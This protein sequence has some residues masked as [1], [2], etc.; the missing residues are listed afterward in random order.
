MKQQY[1][2]HGLTQWDLVTLGMTLLILL[3]FRQLKKL[4]GINPM[5]LS[6]PREYSLVIIYL[7]TV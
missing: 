7:Q 3:P 2:C 5:G 1:Y 6:A 4:I